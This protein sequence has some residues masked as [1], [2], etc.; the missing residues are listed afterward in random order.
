MRNTLFTLFIILGISFT[1][2]SQVKL[3]EGFESSD[4]T[5]LPAGWTVL[6]N[7]SF[8][9][10]PSAN[11]MVR[12]TGRWIPNLTST[13]AKAH[14]GV[15]SAM[16]SWGASIDTITG[17]P[18]ISDAW[19][20]TRK[21][22]NTSATDVLKFWACGGSGS[23]LDSLQIWVSIGDSMPYSFMD[24]LGT[25]TWPPGSIIGNYQIY[26]YNLGSFST[27]PYVYIGF[28]YYMDCNT[29]GYVVFLDDVYVGPPVSVNQ[30]GSNIPTSFSLY[31][32]Y[33]NP[34]NPVTTIKFDVAK[35]ENIKIVVFNTLGA[36]VK[37]VLNER[38]N[39]G[40]YEVKFDASGL[41]SGVYFYRMITST[42]TNTKKLV[43]VK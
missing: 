43:V 22:N 10:D 35:S 39:P 13:R 7:A 1:L 42:Y 14:S 38:K 17:S 6:N 9:I 25:I 33:P 41:P 24:K 32:N 37:T 12:D 11:W 23:Y 31:Q 20:I 21:I 5:V 26:T 2:N 34:F 18:T 15:K 29:D 30:I 8:P 19:L 40:T 16:V 3:S 27:S 36:E 4:S 28:R